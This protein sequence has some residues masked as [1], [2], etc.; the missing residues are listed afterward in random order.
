MPWAILLRGRCRRKAPIGWR[1][2]GESAA[3][4]GSNVYVSLQRTHRSGVFRS[5]LMPRILSGGDEAGDGTGR[6]LLWV[7]R[8][9]NG[10]NDPDLYRVPD[11]AVSGELTM[12]N[13]SKG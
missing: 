7:L 9:T 11:N 10:R 6:F 13:Q 5:R 3:Q 1:T 2:F 12:A 4:G 8:R